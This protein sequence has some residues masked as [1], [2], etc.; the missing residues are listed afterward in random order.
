[1]SSLEIVNSAKNLGT[2]TGAFNVILLE[3]A[4][5][6]IMGAESAKLPV[7][8]QINQKEARYHGAIEPIS[9]A[10]LACAA[11]ASVPTSVHL[12]HADNTEIIR[13]A[14][15]LGYDSIM[16][17]GTN[18]EFAENIKVS[19]Q[20]AELAHSYG[21]TIEVGLGREGTPGSPEIRTNPQE[22]K[23]FMAET[24]ADLLAIVAGS[25]W[26][27]DG[28]AVQL[29]FDLISQISEIVSVPL[30]LHGSSGV[31]D[32]DLKSAVRAGIK[33]VNFATHLKQVFT[34]SIR[35]SLDSDLNAIDPR[36]Y[37]GKARNE[38][39]AEIT[40]LLKMLNLE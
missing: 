28:R 3:H 11:A 25:M 36:S 22:A 17:D 39:A 18:L 5:A 14:L 32:S 19:T 4:E 23:F 30:V 40:R 16:F 26:E 8:L 29:D 1:M 31:S 6:I 2:A 24:G 15:D 37:I 10:T 12:D 35:T 9:L 7:I 38:V 27:I 20:M 21:A 33:K 13:R 34:Q